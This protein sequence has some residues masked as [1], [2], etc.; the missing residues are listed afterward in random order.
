M[1]REKRLLPWTVGK[2]AHQQRNSVYCPEPNRMNLERSCL[3]S[4]E[5]RLVEWDHIA[6]FELPDS[7]HRLPDSGGLQCK[8]RELKKAIWSRFKGWQG[9]SDVVLLGAR[10]DRPD[11]VGPLAD[12][13]KL[14][15]HTSDVNLPPC[16]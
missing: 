8:P 13:L 11:P 3:L 14:H 9:T 16:N 15:T 1:P 2:A 4:D 7:Y 5:N 10:R 6:F 12:G